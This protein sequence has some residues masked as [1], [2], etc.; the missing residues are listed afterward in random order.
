MSQRLYRNR[1]RSVIFGVCA[2]IA[3]YFSFN[4]AATRV[5]VIIASFMFFPLIPFAYV[6]L[7]FLLPIKPAELENPATEPLTRKVRSDPHESI[8]NVRYRFRD[9][10]MRL[11]RLEKYVT[12]KSFRLDREFQQLKDVTE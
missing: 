3:D 5:L 10:D 6:L 2:G 7:G 9:L 12:S 1:T 4:L 8:G 11:Q